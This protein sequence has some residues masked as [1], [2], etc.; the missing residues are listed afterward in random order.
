MTTIIDFCSLSC[1]SRMMTISLL[2]NWTCCIYNRNLEFRNI[3]SEKVFY[4]YDVA[5]YKKLKGLLDDETSGKH[6]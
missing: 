1:I 3:K 4:S 6:N 5:V 2:Y